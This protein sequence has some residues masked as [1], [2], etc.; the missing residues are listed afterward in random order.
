[1]AV[2]VGEK[3]EVSELGETLGKD[4]HKEAADELVSIESHRSC[5]V[6]FF[7]VSLLEGYLA[8]LKGQQAVV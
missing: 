2:V 5:A 7:A 3:A 8:V 6:V 4:M 1:M